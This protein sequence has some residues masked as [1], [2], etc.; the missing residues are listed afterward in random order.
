M[1]QPASGQMSGLIFDALLSCVPSELLSIGGNLLMSSVGWV[2]QADGEL[3]PVL[4]GCIVL[5]VT[6]S[7]FRCEFVASW[8]A[9]NGLLSSVFL[10]DA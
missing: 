9:A 5:A 4:G 1:S 10:C 6:L 7:Q 8:T 2:I 3:L